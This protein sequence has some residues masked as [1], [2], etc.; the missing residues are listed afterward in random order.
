MTIINFDGLISW[1][2]FIYLL[3]EEKRKRQNNQQITRES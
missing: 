2:E 3:A 1:F